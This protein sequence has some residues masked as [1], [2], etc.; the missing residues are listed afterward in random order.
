MVFA[1]SWADVAMAVGA[2]GAAYAA[3]R[4]VNTWKKS[5][6]DTRMH[7]AARDLLIATYRMRDAIEIY[8]DPFIPIY[9]QNPEHIQNGV[10][11]SDRSQAG[12]SAFAYVYR[13]RN[14]LLRKVFV[15]FSEAEL[16]AEA[17]W[18]EKIKPKTERLLTAVN[19]VRVATN[20]LIDRL[21]TEPQNQGQRQEERDLRSKINGRLSDENN[22]TSV[23]IKA[24]ISD[25]EES[26][27]QAI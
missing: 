25:I 15:S 22:A 26:M 18:G 8:R 27:R 23:E 6:E 5:L 13:N 2:L 24:A 9:E 16:V 11:P 12:A 14:K 4:G 7:D 3:I 20:E 10:S 1:E 17:L 21:P 19:G